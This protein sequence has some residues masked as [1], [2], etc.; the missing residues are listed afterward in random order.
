MFQLNLFADIYVNLVNDFFG[1][2]DLNTGVVTEIANIGTNLG[3]A[4][5]NGA[6]YS[7]DSSGNL[8]RINPSNG[9][10][11]IIGNTSISTLTKITALGSS[12]FGVDRSGNVDSINPMTGMATTL[13]PTG[14]G[15][16]M[17]PFVSSFAASSLV[18]YYTQQT[19]RTNAELYTLNPIT[20]MATPVGP[21]AENLGGS[22]FVNNTLLG[23]ITPNSSFDSAV[24]QIISINPTTGAATFFGPTN[25][26]PASGVPI[27]A[28]VP[29]PASL[30]TLGMSLAGLGLLLR[31]R[32]A[33]PTTSC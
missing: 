32:M 33:K 28:S 26:E 10:I 11:T 9:A 18:L 17:N 5:S 3:L 27:P 25:S 13:G 6:L 19:S 2:M 24:A 12:I 14:L 15:A 29:E 22:A 7:V 4:L 21:T 30:I 1:T 31:K 20:G 16:I 23:F 8:I